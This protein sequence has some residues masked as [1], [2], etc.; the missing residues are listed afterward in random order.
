M[1]KPLS[2]H[3]A[4]ERLF[5]RRAFGIKLGLDPIRALLAALG[6]PHDDLCAIHV[7]GT[8]GKG[9]VCAIIDAVLRS[10]GQR[11]GRTTSPHLRQFNER[12]TVD[13]EPIL[14]ADLTSLILDVE[15]AANTVSASIGQELTF[16]ECSTAMAFSHFK[17]AAVQWAVVETGLG[18]RLDATNVLTPV[19]SVITSIGLDHTGFLGSDLVSIAEEKC[20][21]IK[22]GH[23]VVCSAMP[24][25]AEA[26]VRRVAE[27]R[28]S[29]FLSA[30]DMVSVHVKS[31]DLNGQRIV[32]ETASGCGFST[33]FPLLGD[34]Q[35]E[36]LAT[37]VATLEA[38]SMAGAVTLDD[39]AFKSGIAAVRWPGRVDVV[40]S[41]PPVILDGAHNPDA[42]RALSQTVRQVCRGMPVA[43][44]VGMCGDKDLRG[45]LQ[46][47]GGMATICWIVPL[48]NERS[49]ALD[50]MR[51]ALPVS[52]SA[53]HAGPLAEALLAAQDWA[54]DTN[55]AVCVAGSLYL[56]GE[57]LE[58]LGA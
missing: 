47:L 34:H 2:L 23:P 30:K 33:T 8:N 6:D 27:S 12:F 1:M 3:N 37:A 36:N 46:H 26:V 43:L 13:G 16:F 14:D 50:E 45:T 10:A 28:Q 25:D 56:V 7:A 22:A 31:R 41:S 40:A 53:V 19:V 58:V 5:A 38:L 32:V 18:G 49:A 55:G 9:S 39:A 48:Q 35:I 4:V 57:A 44:I 42:A 15:S 51:A 29:A 52:L 24:P 11:V 20:G 17:K 21:I 54:R